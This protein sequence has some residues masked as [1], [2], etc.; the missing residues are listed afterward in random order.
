MVLRAFSLFTLAFVTNIPIVRAADTNPPPRL[1]VD[2]RDGS[3]VVGQSVEKHFKFHSALLGNLKLAVKDIRSIDCVSSNT[4]KLATA[5]GDLL[6]VSFADSEFAVRTSFG[7]VDLKANSLRRVVVLAVKSAGQAREGL[8]ASWLNEGDGKDNVTMVPN[9][10]DLVSMQQTRQLT[11]EAWIKPNS[12]PHEFPVLLSKGGNQ[13]GGAYGGYEFMLNANADNDLVFVSGGCAI[14]THNANG[15]WINNHLGEWIHVAFT[16]DDQTKVAKFYIN[17]Q[18][19][20][21]EYNM[22]TRN[23]LNFDLQN[24]LYIG[25]PD[26]ASNANRSRFDGEMRNLLLFNRAL[27]AAEIRE[28][29]EG[30]HSN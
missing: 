15:R 2:L 13:P 6:T 20:N 23:D 24:N 7:K 17:G 1:T 14:V 21:D 30:G 3:R 9:N 27:T 16:I 10:A 12:I 26:P 4:A 11:F 29:Y 18:S 8:V 5:N 19:T 22:G 25:A 28:D